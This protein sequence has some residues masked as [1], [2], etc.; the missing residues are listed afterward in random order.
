M[1]NAATWN[2]KRS[3]LLIR[4]SSTCC[5]PASGSPSVWPRPTEELRVTDRRLLVTS[6]G[7][8]RLDIAYD[9]LRRIEFDIESG[10]PATMV[11][12]P[13]RTSDEPQVLAIPNKSLHQAAELLAFVGERL[14]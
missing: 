5:N 13:H 14:Q 7:H 11:L 3:R 9:G 1:R 4:R 10:R 8:V 2:P 12:V 6:A